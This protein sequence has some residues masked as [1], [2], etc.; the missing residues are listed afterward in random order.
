MPKVFGFNGFKFHFFSNEGN[1]LEPL[2]IPI[3]KAGSQAKIWIE[4][5]LE[6]AENH[7]FSGAEIR[8]IWNEHF[9]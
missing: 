4:P 1:P 6:L 9:N 5:E 7:G 2:H 8:R 3:R